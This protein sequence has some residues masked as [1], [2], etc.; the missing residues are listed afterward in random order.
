MTAT[1]KTNGETG[2]IAKDQVPLIDKTPASE[3]QWSAKDQKRE[4]SWPLVLFYIHLN[5]LGFYGIIC[6]FT[7][8]SLLTVGF[9]K[10]NNWVLWAA[11]IFISF[12]YYSTCPDNIRNYRSHMRLPSTVESSN[13]HRY[14]R[15]ADLPDVVPNTGWTGNVYNGCMLM[16]STRIIIEWDHR[17]WPAAAFQLHPQA[18]WLF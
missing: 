16:E 7:H 1:D 18:V 3:Q 17:N 14:H 5:I 8:T 11:I 15:A 2:S 12:D 4:V 10:S 13:L 6:L 9:C